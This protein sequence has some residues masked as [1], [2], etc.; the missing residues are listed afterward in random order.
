MHPFFPVTV[1]ELVQISPLVP[2]MCA[3]GYFEDSVKDIRIGVFWTVK[4]LLGMGKKL[5]YTDFI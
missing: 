4:D 1:F 5:C 2:G 3:T